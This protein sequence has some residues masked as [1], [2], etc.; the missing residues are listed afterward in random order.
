MKNI[1]SKLFLILIL[2][3][4][5]CS[6]E[7]YESIEN[8]I[9][10]ESIES[11]DLDSS[12][13]YY[14][15]NKIDNSYF[16]IESVNNR[17]PYFFKDYPW[18]DD[19]IP[20]DLTIFD[21]NNDG[22]LDLVYS[23]TD[24]QSSFDGIRSRRTFKFFIGDGLGNLE[25]DTLNSNKYEGL[26]HCKKSIIGD[27][28]NDGYLD[29]FFAGI[30]PDGRTPNYIPN[31][32]PVLFLNNKNGGF[33]EFRLNNNYGIADGYWHS[34]TSSD[35][36]NDGVSEIILINPKAPWGNISRIIEFE[37]VEGNWSNGLVITELNISVED[38]YS[39]FA[40]ESIDLDGDG[41]DE[42]ILGGQDTD[43]GSIVYNYETKE[44]TL[45]P[46]T[47]NLLIDMI[48]YDLDEDGDLEI[49]CSTNTNYFEGK[50]EILRNDGDSFTNVTD[51]YISDNFNNDDGLGKNWIEWLYIGD[52]NNDGIIE[53]H[54]SDLSKPEYST[55]IW[56]FR[57]NKFVK[58][59]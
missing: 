2:S 43:G 44:T 29:M 10:L 27:W 5:G 47:R 20:S 33:V 59:N 49:I 39:K 57:D 41:I 55:M 21:Y 6:K 38:S 18:G 25:L 11:I 19:D 12:T 24:Y 48:F 53:L 3:L 7:E 4:I 16:G 31:E 34:V 14:S 28:N 40:S 17:L 45:L 51:E 58:I 46:I 36:D 15:Y 22:N 37:D 56:E 35:I 8:N 32:Y 9:I 13:D 1:I 54:T 26:I 50:I 23:N 42:L 30:G 52:F